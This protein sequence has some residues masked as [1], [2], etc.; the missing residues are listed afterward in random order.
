MGVF[1]ALS[2]RELYM[3]DDSEASQDR[4]EKM[5]THTAWCHYQVSS[6]LGPALETCTVPQPKRRPPLSSVPEPRT[7]SSAD[8]NLLTRSLFKFALSLNCFLFASRVI[9]LGGR[10]SCGN[11]LSGVPLARLVYQL[12]DTTFPPFFTISSLTYGSCSS[13]PPKAMPL[14]ITAR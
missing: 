10:K 13:A 3:F 1:N 2:D 14:C 5:H 8:S 12:L 4:S 6:D 7:R 11:G 9:R